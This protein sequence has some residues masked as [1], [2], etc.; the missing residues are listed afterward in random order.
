MTREWM[1]AQLGRMSVLR[2]APESTNEY[3]PIFA[4][5]PERVIASGV[6]Y[7]IRTRSFFPAPAELLRDCDTAKPP[8]PDVPVREPSG[9]TFTA[10][11]RNPFG[12]ADLVL[13][14]DR[15]WNYYCDAC[16][17]IGMRT[18]WSGSADDAGRK[19]WHDVSPCGRR[20]EHGTHEFA[21]R[22]S[23]WDTNPAL[24]RKREREAKYADGKQA[25]R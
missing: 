8:V 2:S 22:C 21:E 7:A 14:V 19:P 20:S 18:F 15:E 4:P 3:W 1:D 9:N 11:I 12:G 16:S 25:D 23:C 17:D 13:T 24:V 6:A 5:L 10:T